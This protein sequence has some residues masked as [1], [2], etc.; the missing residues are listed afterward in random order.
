MARTG[1]LPMRC[2][3]GRPISAGQLQTASVLAMVRP[4]PTLVIDVHVVTGGD[5][6][7][8]AA[9]II[10]IVSSAAPAAPVS[11]TQLLYAGQ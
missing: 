3:A 2:M 7:A 1:T 10:P 6:G 5:N 4:C 11:V 8:G 9:H